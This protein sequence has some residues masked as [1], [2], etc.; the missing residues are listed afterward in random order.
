MGRYRSDYP[1]CGQSRFEPVKRTAID[2]RVW[3]CAWDHKKGR[4]IYGKH[5]TRKDCVLSLYMN[6]RHERLPFE[7]DDKRKGL[8]W[9]KSLTSLEQAMCRKKVVL[10]MR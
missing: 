2:G 5:K 3:W 9:L 8:K 10:R 6:F 4:Y 7:P 1:C